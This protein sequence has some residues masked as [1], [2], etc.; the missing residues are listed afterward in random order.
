[1]KWTVTELQK[2]RDSKLKMDEII[3]VAKE[4]KQ[5]DPEIRDMSPVHVTGRVD[6]DSQ[7]AIFHI[8][9]SGTMVL[10]CSRTLVDVDYPI[11][12]NAMETFLLNPLDKNLD[13]TNQYYVAEAGMIDL[14]PVIEELLLLEIPMQIFAEDVENDH[15]LPQGKGWELMTEEQLENER[16][17]KID[18]RL[19]GLAD[20][21]KSEKE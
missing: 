6:I 13:E 8:H 17:N 12:V 4:L 19:A 10:P 7:K 1:M 2:F 11:D 9:L 5:T 18:P 20:L 15:S 3:D 16:E 14:Q 21:F